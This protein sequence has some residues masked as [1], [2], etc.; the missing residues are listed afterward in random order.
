MD[1]HCLD[2]LSLPAHEAPHARTNAQVVVVAGEWGR[3]AP[4][5]RGVQ[6]SSMRHASLTHAARKQRIQCD[7]LARRNQPQTSSHAVTCGGGCA[8][9]SSQGSGAA[10]R[11]VGSRALCCGFTRVLDAC[12][13]KMGFVVRSM[14]CHTSRHG[15]ACEHDRQCVVAAGRLHPQHNHTDTSHTNTRSIPRQP[16]R[17]VLTGSYCS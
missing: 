10:T 16:A 13:R 15:A 2:A 1:E 9:S 14:E 11:H 8:I 12:S 3:C 17:F 7:L 6:R 5:R 4:G